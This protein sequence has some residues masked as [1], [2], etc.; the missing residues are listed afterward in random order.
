MEDYD[1]FAKLKDKIYNLIQIFY[2]GDILTPFERE[3]ERAYL[4]GKQIDYSL[5]NINKEDKE[6]VN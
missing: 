2:N 4:T 5:E 6:K 1:K 3:I